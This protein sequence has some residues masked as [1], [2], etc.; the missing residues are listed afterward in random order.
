MSGLSDD[1]SLDFYIL[2]LRYLGENVMRHFILFLFTLVF[3]SFSFTLLLI[4]IVIKGCLK[5]QNKTLW[6]VLWVLELKM[7]IR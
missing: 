6:C 2:W 1:E 3:Y 5:K 7:D 4:I